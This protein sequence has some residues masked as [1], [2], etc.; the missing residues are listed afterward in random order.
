RTSCHLLSNSTLG[1]HP[2]LRSRC[3]GLV[4]R[5]VNPDAANVDLLGTVPTLSFAWAAA[6]GARRVMPSASWYFPYH[7]RVRSR[8]TRGDGSWPVHQGPPGAFSNV[9]EPPKSGFGV[10]MTAPTSSRQAA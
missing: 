3:H 4:S 7:F 2:L 8:T 5:N 10:G 1:V 9:A 6:C